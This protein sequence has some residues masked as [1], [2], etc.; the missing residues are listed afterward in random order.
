MLLPVSEFANKPP[1]QARPQSSNPLTIS[2]HTLNSFPRPVREFNRF[3]EPTQWGSGM[4]PQ[5]AF[6]EFMSKDVIA[7]YTRDRSELY[8]MYTEMKARPQTAKWALHTTKVPPSLDVVPKVQQ[9]KEYPT[10]IKTKKTELTIETNPKL[11]TEFPKTSSRNSRTFQLHANKEQQINKNPIKG[12]LE[13]KKEYNVQ[14]QSNSSWKPFLGGQTVTNTSS[15]KY[16][17]ITFEPLSHRID[18]TILDDKHINYKKKGVTEYADLT[19]TY[20]PNYNTE[21]KKAITNKPYRFRRFTGLFTN[22]YDA[23]IRN[24]GIIK[25]FGK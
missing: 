11:E 5:T 24:G 12:F 7:P 9:F 3:Q 6:K 16:N 4:N 14:K 10:Q 2:N 25:V 21:F 8:P 1:R 19:K 13:M 15:K 22:M 20:R 17:I 23:S 18:K